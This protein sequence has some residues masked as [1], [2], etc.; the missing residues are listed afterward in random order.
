MPRDITTTVY[1]FDELSEAAQ[2]KA[3]EE[4]RERLSGA[5]WDQDDID[6]VSEAMM[7]KLTRSLVGGDEAD[8]VTG[9]KI[10]GWDLDRDQLD[11]SGELTRKNAPALAWVDGIEFV[12]LVHTRFA[13]TS[14]TPVDV[15]PECT[16]TN[17]WT[18][19][20]ELTCPTRQPNPISEDV[21]EAFV[22]TVRDILADACAAGRG[23]MEHR[24]SEEHARDNIEANGYEFEEDG[25]F[26]G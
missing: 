13:G 12:Q 6:S 8:T 18:A 16:C 10:E 20:H 23:E 4:I 1:Q 26:A 17:E 15:E 19:P 14:I 21:R 25:T 3:V 11:V 22:Q 24:S 5:W 7:Y 2:E 9:V